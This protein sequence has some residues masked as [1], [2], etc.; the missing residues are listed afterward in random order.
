MATSRRT[1]RISSRS[2]PSW[3]P[4]AS[5]ALSRISPAPSSAAR[6]AHSIAS[7]PADSRPP[8]VVT[9][10]PDGVPERAAGVDG[11][12]QNL[13]AEAVGD[14]RDQLGAT[15]RGGVDRDLVGART[16]QHG[17]RPR[18]T[19]T[20]A[21]GE[22]DEDLLGGPATRSPSWSP[23]PRGRPRC[24]GRSA[25]RR[26][27]R[28]RVRASS[29]GSPASR[30]SLK[31][32][33]LTTR[34]ASTS[35]HGMTRTARV[36]ASLGQRQRVLEREP[37]LVE[38]GPDDRA[39]DAVRHQVHQRRGCRRASVTPPEATTGAVGGGADVAQ[40]LEVRALRA[41]RPC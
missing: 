32:M 31:L 36:T 37:A 22:R 14:L 15:D 7:R 20:P 3:V 10:K 4:S 26:P 29:T 17:R 1:A 27:R 34:P 19:H 5:I 18:P 39:L 40:Q 13:V 6:T 25:R 24:R 30:S 16:Q 41:C 11:Q 33:P 28:R 12:H 35:R 38:R 23:G 8:C 9:S 21:D 2:K